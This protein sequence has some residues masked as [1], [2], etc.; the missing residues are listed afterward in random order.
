MPI[1]KRAFTLCCQNMEIPKIDFYDVITTELYYATNFLIIFLNPEIEA[2]RKAGMA[3]N[4]RK[5]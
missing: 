2:R 1:F 4:Y 3:F 5:F